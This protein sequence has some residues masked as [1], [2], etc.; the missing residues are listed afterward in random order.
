MQVAVERERN[1]V[2]DVNSDLQVRSPRVNLVVD[3]DRAAVLGLD[4]KSIENALYSG[5]GPKWSSTIYGPAN[6][7]EVLLEIQQ[8]YQQFSDY[9]SKIYFR[10]NNNT[11]VPLSEI[12]KQTEDVMPQTINH[13]GTRHR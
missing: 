4:A 13:T 3:R 10:T 8:K 6:Q 2:T 11:L 12:V 5:Y 1:Y 9:L 7:Y